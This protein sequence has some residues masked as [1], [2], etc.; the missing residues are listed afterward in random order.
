[1]ISTFFFDRWRRNDAHK[2]GT[3]TEKNSIVTKV[4]QKSI[5]Q[6]QRRWVCKVEK[7]LKGSLDLI[8]SPSR[9]REHLNF[10]F[11]I[12]FG[13]TLLGIVNKLSWTKSLL[14]VPNNVLLKKI[15]QKIQMFTTPWRWWNRIQ[16]TF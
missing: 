1:M 14:T 6:W 9:S 11:F 13:K 4:H 3:S 15:K 5:Y 10:Y 12:F 8:L 2:N 16:A 7:I